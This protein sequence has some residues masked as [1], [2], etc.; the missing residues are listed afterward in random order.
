MSG[1]VV[2]TGGSYLTGTRPIEEILEHFSDAKLNGTGWKCKCPNHDDRVASLSISEGD[3]GKVL[4]KCHAGCETRDVLAKVGLGF[5]DLFA[6]DAPPQTPKAQRRIV[7]TYNYVDEHGSPLFRVLRYEPK[8]FLQQRPD[9]KN[10]WTWGLEGV[11]RVPFQ[12]P[13]LLAANPDEWVFVCEGEEDAI[14][15][16]ALGFTAT[17]NPMGAGKWRPEYTEHFHGRR[18][19]ILPDRDEAG[20]KHAA[21]VASSLHGTASDIRVVELPGVPI[22]G[23]VRDW[24]RAGGA[25]ESLLALVEQT[26]SWEDAPHVA[27]IPES[28]HATDLG[29]AKRLVARH[30][31]DLRYCQERDCWYA[32]DGQRWNVD[33]SGE[34]PRRAK[35][36]VVSMYAEA[37]DLPEAERKA[38]IRHAL[39]S[40]SASRIKAMIS[41]AESEPGI[42][43]MLDALDRDPWLLNVQNGTIDLRTGELRP[44]NRQDLITRL[45]PID[46]DPLAT[47]PTWDKFL[48]HVLSGKADLIK[49][50]QRAAGYS[51]T[52]ITSERCFFLLYGVGRNGKSTLVETLQDVMADLAATTP[53]E[54]LLAT[55]DGSIPNDIAALKGVRFVAASETG[56]GRKLA[57]AKIKALTG[58]DTISARFM[59]GEFFNFRPVFK[60][61]LSTNHKPKITE[62][63]DAIW[64]RIRLIPFS[65]RIPKEQEDKRLR[66][67]LQAE[68]PG[69]LAWAVDGCLAWQQEGLLEPADVMAATDAYRQESDLL[70]AFIED[71]CVL[72]EKV[73][74]SARSLYAAYTQ[75]CE[76]S[77]ERTVT[78]TAFGK[79]LTERGFERELVGTARMRYWV[80]IGLKGGNE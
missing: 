54:T 25:P 64:D 48:Q 63:T 1:R 80:G 39:N 51:L 55:R 66:A 7:K 60:L 29:N 47:C 14:A 12:L 4:V 41:L 20:S 34:I 17:T 45:S 8:D 2:S 62:T 53:T 50:I 6:K 46:Y 10:G 77:G 33:Q 3:D 15:L 26:P 24:L 32:F 75:W 36:T 23:D 9:G 59:R 58:G 52:G 70:G 76:E 74:A 69:I 27:D 43:V 35:D 13:E 28:F 44:H 21:Q 38:L 68:L 5:S 61:W 40:E 18:V 37:A 67:K 30:G 42:P 56:E 73:Q 19:V 49:F 16:T 71:A 22:K 11:R 72:G 65:V 79:S 78:Q 57:E 31:E